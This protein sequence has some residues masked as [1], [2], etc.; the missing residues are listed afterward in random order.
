M[1]SSLGSV[2]DEWVS[3][4]RSSSGGSLQ[5]A[6]S[7]AS[8]ASS[9]RSRIP[10]PNS[11]RRS[12]SASHF[13]SLKTLPPVLEQDD[14]RAS[15]VLSERSPSETNANGST[16]PSRRT[17]S[18]QLKDEAPGARGRRISR[19]VSSLAFDTTRHQTVQQKSQSSSPPKARQGVVTPEWRKRLLHGQM[20]YREMK[21]L[22]SPT[23]LENVFRP[24]PPQQGKPSSKRQP[25]MREEMP[26]SPP[27]YDK[28]LRKRTFE[29]QA[30][31][32]QRSHNEQTSEVPNRRK[33]NNRVAGRDISGDESGDKQGVGFKEDV[34]SEADQT[35]PTTAYRVE[36]RG[37]RQSS[38]KSGS[39]HNDGTSYLS[40][41][42]GDV[43][44]DISPI[45]ISK[46]NTVDGRVDYAALDT[47]GK[48]IRQELRDI[49]FKNDDGVQNASNGTME[50][51]AKGGFVNLRRGG[52]SE[53]GSFQHR[54]LSPSSM[55]I[56]ENSM[57][58]QG[59]SFDEGTP[60]RLPQIRQTRDSSEANDSALSR[61]ATSSSPPRTPVR[62]P[63]REDSGRSKSS[64]SP[65][66]LFGT[67]D[68][69]TNNKLLRRISEF[70][71]TIHGQIDEEDSILEAAPME[72]RE[73][74]T[75]G[76]RSMA[77]FKF[78]K[79][80]KET[81]RVSS[82]RR[83]E[84][85][86]AQ[87]ERI[88]T[89]TGRFGLGDLD[90]YAFVD[91]Y[92]L[93]TTQ[94]EDFDEDRENQPPLPILDRTS[95][96]RFRFSSESVSENQDFDVSQRRIS[97]RSIPTKNSTPERKH[98]NEHQDQH[99]A[100][101]LEEDPQDSADEGESLQKELYELSAINEDRKRS[102]LSP[103]KIRSSKRRRTLNR[104]DMGS[105]HTHQHLQSIL[106]KK[107][108]D[109]RYDDVDQAADPE[110]LAS[111]RIL[112]PRNPTPSQQ[113]STRNSTNT[114]ASKKDRMIEELKA[115]HRDEHRKVSPSEASLPGTG[116]M[117]KALAAMAVAKQPQDQT[118][119]PSV[120]TQD[121]YDEA[122][123]IMEFIRARGR[124][125]S[126]LVSVEESPRMDEE[127]LE[128]HESYE[129][130]ST[131]DEFERPPSREGAAR[132]QAE[133]FQQTDPR[134]ISHLARFSEQND[135]EGVINSSIRMRS[136][137]A[138]RGTV[139]KYP[140]AVGIDQRD[141]QSIRISENP[142]ASRQRSISQC[143]ARETGSSED[144]QRSN[145]SS[146]LSE[147]T[148]NSG[149][150][151]T[152]KI[153]QIHKVS[154]LI[155][156]EIAGMAYDSSKQAWVKRKPTPNA[157]EADE[158][159]KSENSDVDPFKNIP[160]L[161]VNETDEL[162]RTREPS[163]KRRDAGPRLI[164]SWVAGMQV[165]NQQ[166]K[167]EASE[168]RPR[169]RDE[170]IT[171]PEN[172]SSTPSKIS[173]FMSS[174]QNI[175]TR[176]TSWGDDIKSARAQTIGHAPSEAGKNVSEQSVQQQITVAEI[177]RNKGRH[178]SSHKASNIEHERSLTIAFSS[179][180]VSHVHQQLSQDQ[181]DDNG[182]EVW[183]D[184]NDFELGDSGVDSFLELENPVKNQ[185]RLSRRQS[186]LATQRSALSSYPRRVSFGGRSFSGRPVSRI[187]EHEEVGSPSTPAAGK[188]VRRSLDMT[189]A[190]PQPLR[191]LPGSTTMPP[192]TSTHK[193]FVSFHLSPLPDFT[194]HEPDESYALEI[195]HI[196]KRWGDLSIRGAQA[197]L[198][199]ATQELV[200][201][202]TDVEPYEPYWDY[203]QRIDLSSKNLITLYKLEEYCPRIE[204]LVASDNGLGQVS[205]VPHSVRHLNVA[206]NS[207]SDLTAWGHLSNLQFIDISGNC[208]Q[209]L[210]GFKNLVHLRELKADDNEIASL[211]GVFELEGL[212]SLRMR[213]NKL[214]NVNFKEANWQYL[215]ELDLQENQIVA[216]ENL[217]K[218]SRLSVVNLDKNQM[219]RFRLDPSKPLKELQILKARDNQLE[220]LDVSAIPSVRALYLDKNHL[221]D[222]QGLQKCKRLDTLSIREQS[223]SRLP[224]GP[225]EAAQIVPFDSFYE[226]RKLYL[227]GTYI[228]CSYD[229]KLSI[230]FLNLQ[231]L[232]LASCGLSSLPHRL[233][234]L[235]PNVRVVN[236]NFNAISSLRP[237][238]GMT[239]LKKLY[240]AG[241]RVCRL[242]RTATL[243]KQFPNL[244]ALD[245]RN[246]PLT[247]G[248]YPP[249]KEARLVVHAD[250]LNAAYE[251]ESDSK[252]DP[253]LLPEVHISTDL[254]ND[255]A[256]E[257]R[258]DS[259]TK[260]RRRVY[261]M[262]LS[263][264]LGYASLKKLDGMKLKT[265]DV[266]KKDEIW[267]KLEKMG[268]LKQTQHPS[269]HAADK[270]PLETIQEASPLI[271]EPAG[272]ANNHL[273]AKSNRK[274]QSSK[275]PC[276]PAE[277]RG[278]KK[279]SSKDSS[280]LKPRKHATEH[281]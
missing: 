260:F 58:E 165:G 50:Y 216:V 208:I 211:G 132:R 168:S 196:V 170:Q 182:E 59:R 115:D 89:G 45:F 214:T 56:P 263:V 133:P 113:I 269:P 175:E 1:S 97:R 35:P 82:L 109:A 103:Y 116:T 219:I 210:E 212:M 174:E 29:T 205:G 259:T 23:G 250:Q 199:I 74:S 34:L 225:S 246:N 135:T 43:D 248:F 144:S 88:V 237:L 188:N 108:K 232:Q 265:K 209:S 157:T 128:Y 15:G 204:D 3:P 70:E 140:A 233:G 10:R 239:R 37:L 193:S 156:E 163:P 61:D 280:R 24:P 202:L 245:L 51:E 98:R 46:H 127:P 96:S 9:V 18:K 150:S 279:R 240:A 270:A 73:S 25:A 17:S 69:F 90:D 183:R 231:S 112:R 94:D 125:Q 253:F 85:G 134:I 39:G 181:Y 66:K 60:Q 229:F 47:P 197:G 145:P 102:P 78:E 4:P 138:K 126:G 67:Y 117:T 195:N 255:K 146:K 213:R 160:D 52:Y 177:S 81:S 8:G 189:L 62:S 256:W 222:V 215:C 217:H 110:V 223:F 178:L 141:L 206:R 87:E 42:Q 84:S 33:E 249:I 7:Q 16:Q 221:R 122:N 184:A 44:E 41:S 159:A 190:T 198:E 143:S 172:W 77:Q 120:T 53:E 21:D 30:S 119:K 267:A 130:Q 247:L 207:L 226:T 57:L 147:R 262:L 154:H 124:P 91:E 264:N 200:K 258:L 187:S 158:A 5:S 277:G 111:R 268:V 22:F 242:R 151:D 266:L 121:F 100:I 194:I 106:S 92:S 201:R 274:A 224:D 191:D 19:T 149:Q 180:L 95:Q 54:N 230:Q 227:S 271:A 171:Q 123:K 142:S 220:L 118:R 68:T 79:A 36:E 55:A 105:T 235:L 252:H 114:V 243:L 192:P 104:A 185:P 272:K 14:W 64:G 13:N 71:D 164:S 203:I 162:V 40:V 218:L 173:R 28:H 76:D 20:G 167:K 80:T 241:N 99:E 93:A 238:Q 83:S 6:P 244:A 11:H 278:T 86:I 281:V 31:I 148:T 139:S 137:S 27:P 186:S 12:I 275:K 257:S 155:P 107:R 276:P 236:L 63:A 129:D 176:A 48:Q 254:E 75:R 179:P 38:G 136:F 2:S 161:S 32:R 65:L 228:P 153:I 234:N 169:T 273:D 131:L 49:S 166:V 152:R 251:E 26:S 101:Y 261:E 72:S